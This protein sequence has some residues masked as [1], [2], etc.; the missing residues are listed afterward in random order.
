MILIETFVIL[1]IGTTI[2]TTLPTGDTLVMGSI[3]KPITTITSIMAPTTG[4]A[5]PNTAASLV[6][7]W[8][9][10]RM[11]DS[12]EA[13]DSTEDRVAKPSMV[14]AALS[15][16]T[17]REAFLVEEAFIPEEALREEV[18]SMVEAAVMVEA[19]EEAVTAE[20]RTLPT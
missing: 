3:M 6:V 1:A 14:E 20:H 4:L 10:A 13:K 12:M 19:V 5:I 18:A 9:R 16:R 15:P 11:R 17:E 2:G 7:Q 8:L